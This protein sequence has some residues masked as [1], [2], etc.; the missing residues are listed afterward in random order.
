MGFLGFFRD[1]P[2]AWVLGFQD[3]AD[4]VVEEIVFFHDQVMFLLIIIVTVVLWLIV[5]A[6]WNKFYDRNLVDG[7]FLEI[8]WTIIPA[9][10][11]IFIALPSLKLLY[12][13]DEIISPALTI[14]V[15][16][17]QWY[18]SY[19]YSD[20]EGET[21]AFD[22]YMVPSSDLISGKNRLLE[23]DQKLVVPIGTHIRFLVTGA[24]VLHS[25][26]VPS[27]GLKV[28]AVPGRL[29]QTGVFIKRPGVFFGQCSEI[30]GANHSFMPIVIEG[31]GLNEYIQHLSF[32]RDVL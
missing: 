26:A 17:H 24:D 23:V 27:L 30:C 19:E 6:F 7:T 4:P 14:K 21:L 18:W 28:D 3:V 32:W 15:I 2:E 5:E 9:V 11:L 31:V 22:S 20:Y 29:N 25:F 1:E 8:V 10:I 12:L 13:M 16:G